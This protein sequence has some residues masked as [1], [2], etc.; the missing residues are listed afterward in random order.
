MQQ[1]ETDFIAILQ[2]LAEHHVEFM[3]VGGISAVLQGAPIATFDLDVVHSLN[4]ENIQRLLKAL[5]ELDASYR[6]VGRPSLKPDASHLGSS[7]H[8]LLITRFGPLDIP[9]SIGKGRKYDD[10]LTS[11]QVM[12]AG[13]NLEVRVLD[14]SMVIQTKEETASEKDTAVLPI[15]RRTLEE[16]QRC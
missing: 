13:P 8:Q 5:D 14:L 3:V 9:G 7:G 12:Q 2:S 16:K 15:L 6:T 1:G 4:A 10:L 11:S